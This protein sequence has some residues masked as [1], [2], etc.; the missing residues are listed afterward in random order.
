[1][2]SVTWFFG[3]V[4]YDAVCNFQQK[5]LDMDANSAWCGYFGPDTRSMLHKQ[6]N[7]IGATNYYKKV[8]EEEY[9]EE[10][11]EIINE[12]SV[13]EEKEVSPE[14]NQNEVEEEL[15][16]E[17]ENK[18][19]PKKDREWNKLWDTDPENMRKYREWDAV[20]YDYRR[21]IPSGENSREVKLLQRKLQVMWHYRQDI[22]GVYDAYMRA[23]M[24]ELQRNHGILTGDDPAH[25]RG[26]FWPGTRAAING[27]K[28]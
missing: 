21:H 11:D 17:E 20:W 16:E 3:D 13:A 18:E 24:Y 2:D 8:A 4:T 1:M 19:E 22:N 10:P 14:E 26:Y 5:F 27:W 9:F 12:H 25:L 15:E 23:S 6:A 28:Y 7:Q